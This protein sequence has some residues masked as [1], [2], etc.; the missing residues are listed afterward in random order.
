MHQLANISQ[1][2]QLQATANAAMGMSQMSV[3]NDQADRDRIR[4][5]F[6]DAEGDD[7]VNEFFTL[8]DKETDYWANQDPHNLT[9]EQIQ[10]YRDFAALRRQMQQVIDKEDRKENNKTMLDT[11]LD[12]SCKIPQD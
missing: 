12:S 7:E 11:I 6:Q 1:F 2:E 10:E 9:E 5:L 3:F 4:Y 8:F